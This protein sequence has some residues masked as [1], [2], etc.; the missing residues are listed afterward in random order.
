MFPSKLKHD[1]VSASSRCGLC[2]LKLLYVN[3]KPV[4]LNLCITAARSQRAG[5]SFAIF[6]SFFF[7]PLECLKRTRCSSE[8]RRRYA[9]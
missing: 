3:V 1:N 6:F 5:I 2:Y 8:E 9:A 4:E 7:E